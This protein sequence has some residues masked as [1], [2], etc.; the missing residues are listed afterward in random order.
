MTV[1]INNQQYSV[2]YRANEVC[3]CINTMTYETKKVAMSSFDKN[4]AKEINDM[5]EKSRNEFENILLG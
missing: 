1:I 4:V 5:F 2:I 3:H